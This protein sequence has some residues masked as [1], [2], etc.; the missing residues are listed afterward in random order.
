MLIF[1]QDRYWPRGMAGLSTPIAYHLPTAQRPICRELRV[2]WYRFNYSD[3]IGAKI[4]SE[5]CL[6]PYSSDYPYHRDMAGC[7]TRLQ[8]YDSF[9]SH[10]W[11]C[12]RCLLDISA[13]HSTC[14][15]NLPIIKYASLT[16]VQIT[17]LFFVHQRGRVNA[18]Y[19]LMNN[20]GVCYNLD[21]LLSR[22]R[23][24]IY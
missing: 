6:S 18:I 7:S 21:S 5:T 22:L 1:L 17:D 12:M 13:Y 8:E 11:V 14:L 10:Q 15:I 19:Q 23:F 24:C 9:S 16:E 2:P 20:A 3:P 4:W